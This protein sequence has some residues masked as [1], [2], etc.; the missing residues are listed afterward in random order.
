MSKPIYYERPVPPEI[1]AKDLWIQFGRDIFGK[2]TRTAPTYSYTWIADQMGHIGIGII[3]DFVATFVIGLLLGFLSPPDF[4]PR[5]FGFLIA[6]AGVSFWEYSTYETAVAEAT[7][8]FPL[9]EKLVRRNAVTAA[10]YMIIGAAI[11]FSFHH[12]D[13]I[14]GLGLPLVLAGIAVLLAPSW[15]RQKMTWQKAGIP[16]LFRVAD[17]PPEFID[18]AVPAKLQAL[19]EQPAPGPGDAV[20]RQ[21]VV[22]GPVESGRTSLACGIGTEF[23]FRNATVRYLSFDDLLEFA[24]ASNMTVIPPILHDD[25]GPC[26]IKYWEWNRAQILI[27]DDIGPALT[28]DGP[29]QGA[30]RF[31][32]LLAGPLKPIAGELAKRHTVWIFG[33]LGSSSDALASCV[34]AVHA[35]CDGK[36]PPLVVEL[37]HLPDLAPKSRPKWPDL[38]A[39]AMKLPD[40][41]TSF[42]E[43]RRR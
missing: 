42:I 22:A 17:M 33:D 2:E 15:L 26:T 28:A 6:A 32:M 9:D 30:A 16:Y 4:I 31:R 27:I 21:I 7:Q 12:D 1:S 37:K 40:R 29:E 11:G 13:T 34:G 41:V 19:I 38:L 14:L 25:E 39:S 24:A 43:A 3:A 23:A 18:E 35:F 10:A 5:F 36:E 8:V 20:P